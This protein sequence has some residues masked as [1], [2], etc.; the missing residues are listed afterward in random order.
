MR[1]AGQFPCGN[2]WKQVYMWSP[3]MSPPK[4]NFNHILW[5]C[6]CLFLQTGYFR[7]RMMTRNTVL[8]F[9]LQLFEMGKGVGKFDHITNQKYLHKITT[10]LRQI[11]VDFTGN[12]NARSLRILCEL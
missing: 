8:R 9:F 4:G 2:K 7:H 5:K 11:C 10:V 12:R 6:F 3:I 1:S